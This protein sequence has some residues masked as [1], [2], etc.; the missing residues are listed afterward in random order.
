MIPFPQSRPVR[1]LLAAGA[2]CA[3]AVALAGCGTSISVTTKGQAEGPVLAVGVSEDAP[4]M[5]WVH[6]ATYQGFEVTVAEYV[7]KVLG[8]S[9]KQ[10]EY[11][12]VTPATLPGLVAD[13]TVELAVAAYPVT[14][15]TSENVTFAGPYLSVQDDLLVRNDSGDQVASLDDMDGRTACAVD[16][17]VSGDLLRAEVPGVTIETESTYAKCVSALLTG[18]ADAVVAGAPIVYGLA[19]QAGADYAK[20]LEKPFG[21]ENYGIAVKKGRTELADQVDTALKSMIDDGSWQ[22]AVDEMTAFT[23]YVPDSKLD[24]PQ[25][26]AGDAT[27][28]ADASSGD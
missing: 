13:G 20:V 23:G 15:A 14:D 4:G 12:S 25:V 3:V 28:T 27:A 17:S 9:E 1:R 5:G 6:N 2:A 7:G 21:V 16:G 8:Y 11:T 24:P 10:I 18:M 26:S 19:E 22:A